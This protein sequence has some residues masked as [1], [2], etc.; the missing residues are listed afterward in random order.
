MK[1][2]VESIDT[3]CNLKIDERMSYLEF[4]KTIMINLQ[5]SLS[6]EVLRT[7]RKGAYHCTTV[8]DCNTRKY[9]GLLVM[10]VPELDDEN[11]VILSSFDETVI[12]HGAEFNLGLHKYDGD[13]YSPN[14][15]KYIREYSCEIVP[16]TLYRVGGVILSKEKIFSQ[17]DNRIMIKYTLEDAH[18][19]TT[20]R[21]RPFLAFRS[22]KE[23]TYENDAINKSYTEVP[24]GIKMCLYH[25]YPELFMQ[26]NKKVEF[27]SDPHW[28]RGLEY[29]KEQ[30]RGFPYKEDL[31]V[32]GYFEIPIKKGE[33]IIF[34]AGDTQVATSTLKSQYDKEITYR[35]PRTSFINCLKNSAQQFYFRPKGRESHYLLAGYPWFKVRARDLF[36]SAPGCTLSVDAPERFEAILATAMPAIRNFMKDGTLDPIIKEIDQPDVLLWCINAIQQYKLDQGIERCKALYGEFV[37]EIIE[38]ILSQKHPDMR[39][40]ENGLLYADGRE[41]A[42]TWMNSTVDGKPVVS[43]SGYIVEFNALWYNTLC[44]YNKELN[45]NKPVEKITKLIETI[46]KSFV[47]TFVNG[48]KY[49]F[50]SV[51]GS[52]VDWSVRPNMIFAVALPYSPLEKAEQRPILDIVTK[53]LRTPKG[54]RSLSPKSEGYRPNYVGPQRERDLSYHQGTAWPWLLGAYLESYLRIF[55]KSGVSFVRRMLISMEEEV[56]LHCIG[57]IPELFD[58]NPPFT[59]RGAISFAMNV[60]AILRVSKILEKYD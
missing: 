19:A 58:G 50:D 53:E 12:Q 37:E 17:N 9:H 6:R 33:V 18:S 52:K 10:P 26:F 60:A 16:R 15:H 46:K 24:H 45:E 43:R 38:Y 25:G 21:F 55:G 14:G 13:H 3:N 1:K 31:F 49:L 32:P 20:L 8:V 23:L 56:K 7:N 27:V 5:E 39:V 42:I 11:H 29:P 40:T 47:E 28:Y 41:K 57:T 48:Y 34:N 59:G 44:F 54:I 2:T 36:I 4:D 30:E 35:I 22:V 51:S